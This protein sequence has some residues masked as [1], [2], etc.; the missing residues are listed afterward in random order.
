MSTASQ[1]SFGN[2][3]VLTT[4]TLSGDRGVTAGSTF[5]SFLE[6][7]GNVSTAGQFDSGT[8][9]PSATTRLNY[10]GNLYVTNLIGNYANGNS[11]ISIP[12]AN[13]NVTISAGGTSNVLVISSTGVT[14]NGAFVGSP[15]PRVVVL[16]DATSVTFNASTTDLAEQT[17]TQAAGTLSINA[18]TGSPVDG[19]KLMFRLQSANVQTFS[20]N[21]V[22]AGSTD[23]SLPTA[24]SGSNKY[25]YIGFIYNSTAVQWQMIAKNFG[26]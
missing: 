19:Q 26:F 9:N 25:D 20:W 17:N 24:S 12:S 13:G 2:A 22:F 18:V 1:L 3:A 5:S 7:N 4:G 15:V 10:N 6:Y 11:N 14:V 23:L 16:A 8:T 21:A